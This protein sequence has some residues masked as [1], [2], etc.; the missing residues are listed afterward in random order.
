MMKQGKNSKK[1]ENMTFQANFTNLIEV[2]HSLYYNEMQ[3]R[4]KVKPSMFEQTTKPRALD[5]IFS[6][7]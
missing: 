3:N 2:Y 5:L 7:N 4:E 1:S 6:Q